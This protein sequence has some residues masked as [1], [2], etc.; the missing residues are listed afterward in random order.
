MY[1][2]ERPPDGGL[3]GYGEALWWTAMLLTTLG[4][5]YEP[6]T[7]EGRLLA[8]L[9]ALFAFSVFGYITATLASLF[10]GQDAEERNEQQLRSE[11]IALHDELRALR[12][13]LERRD[14]Q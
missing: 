2:F 4:A 14:Q 7:L 1:T 3:A 11:I 10:V 8:W 13:D 9:L 12:R 6:Q 5:G